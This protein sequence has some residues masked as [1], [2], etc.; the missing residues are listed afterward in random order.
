VALRGIGRE[1]LARLEA[2]PIM[3][4]SAIPARQPPRDRI[5]VGIALRLLAVALFASLFALV[6]LVEQRGVRVI[7]VTFWRQLFAIP[8]LLLWIMLGPGL[9]S[10]KTSRID[11][12]LLRMVIGLTGILCNFIVVML[13][14]L[15]EAMTL[16]FTV[17]IF[18]TIL[19]AL[20][21]KETIGWHRSAA[22]LAGFSGVLIVAQ[23]WNGH[24]PLAGTAA[25]LI[26]AFSGA[27]LAILLRRLSRTET[28]LAI[29]FWFHL[30]SLPPLAVAYVF[31]AEPHDWLSWVM[32]VGTGLLGGAGQLAMTSSITVAPVS[33][34]APLDYSSLIWGAL[35]G[36]LVFGAIPGV[37]MWVGAA[38]IVASSLYIIHRDHRRR[39][40]MADDPS[41]TAIAPD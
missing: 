37:S 27:V 8:P 25:G 7:E 35:F 10:I 34:V 20:V 39:G 16:Q 21:L 26:S 17:P 18:A 6:K 23:P 22:V 19:G 15:A 32:L 11:A 9:R 12:H 31:Y 5:P 24:F 3:T 38:I 13:M 36:W 1:W 2:L 40:A 14:P 4:D 30:L 33:V 29:V 41:P 28:P